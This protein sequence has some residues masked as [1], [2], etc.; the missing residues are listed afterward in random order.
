MQLTKN[1]SLQEI[2]PEVSYRRYGYNSLSL[3]SA[4]IIEGTQ[5]VIDL[6]GWDYVVMNT[7]HNGGNSH[8][9]GLRIKGQKYYRDGM[10]A[11]D[12]GNAIDLI[13]YQEGKPPVELI[14]E[15]HQKVSEGWMPVVLYAFGIRRIETIDLASTWIHLDCLFNP[16]QHEKRQVV[17]IDRTKRYYP[18]EYWEKFE[19]YLR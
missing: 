4:Q 9:R 16:E 14:K 6:M 17:F 3:M 13:P 10:G 7:W 5:D 15:F 2:V 1:I 19:K 11:H 18:D 12:N 8:Q